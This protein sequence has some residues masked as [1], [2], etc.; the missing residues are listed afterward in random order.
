MRGPAAFLTRLEPRVFEI[1]VRL[2]LEP[3]FHHRLLK[4]SEATRISEV[5]SSV[6]DA[7]GSQR[8]VQLVA[9]PVWFDIALDLRTKRKFPVVYDCHDYL[10][11]FEGIAGDILETEERVF[12]ESDLTICSS[13]ALVARAREHAVPDD[14]LLLLRNAAAVED[15]AGIARPIGPRHPTVIGY[16]GALDSWFDIESVATAAGRHADWR[17]EL[18]GRIENLAV[19]NLR[20]FSNVHFVGEVPYQDLPKYLSAF[21]LAVIPFLNDALTRAT[22]PIKAYEYLAAGLPVL[23]ARLP[24]LYRLRDVISFYD[25]PDDFIRQAESLLATDSPALAQ[26]RTEVARGET[27]SARCEVLAPHLARLIAAG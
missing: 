8:L 24:E 19:E 3:V 15:F 12:R 21:S 18:I 9:F 22:D 1:H 17:I 5:I 11:G 16:V 25:N 4:R 13:D 10:P 6:A 7:F 23:S 20:S 27:W 2:P 26:R 14:R